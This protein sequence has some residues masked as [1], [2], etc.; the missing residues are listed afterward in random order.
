MEISRSQIEVMLTLVN[1]AQSND[2]CYDFII[3]NLSD[4]EKS[5]FGT[6]LL[7]KIIMDSTTDKFCMHVDDVQSFLGYNL[8]RDFLTFMRRHLSDDDFQIRK[9]IDANKMGRPKEVHY[10]TIDSVCKLGMSAQTP[11]G[12]ETRKYY[13][14]LERLLIEFCTNKMR[15]QDAVIQAQEETIQKL[16]GRNMINQELGERVYVFQDASNGIRIGK[17]AWLKQRN[18]PYEMHNPNGNMEYA[19][20][21][22]NGLT[23][24]RLTHHILNQFHAKDRKSWYECD[25]T[26]AHEVINTGQIFLD[27]LVGY[28]EYLEDF[29]MAE[30]MTELMNEYHEFYKSKTSSPD[31]LSNMTQSE[32]ETPIHIQNVR[33]MVKPKEIPSSSS[34]FG[35][36]TTVAMKSQDDQID[37]SE[38]LFQDLVSAENDP[39]NLAKFVDDL[40]LIDKDA[41]VTNGQVTN[42]YKFWCNNT[43][44]DK[45]D[46]MLVYMKGRFKE[47]RGEYDGVLKGRKTILLGLKLRPIIWKLPDTPSHFDRFVA[48]N[49]IVDCS[50]RTRKTR[51]E[52]AYKTWVNSRAETR[53]EQKNLNRQLTL[54]EAHLSEHFIYDIVWLGK[55]EGQ[56]LGYLGIGIPNELLGVGLHPVKDARMGARR[57]F[58]KDIGTGEIVKMFDTQSEAADYL[59][60]APSAVTIAKK[61]K[62]AICHGQYLILTV[63]DLSE[64]EKS[65]IT[66]YNDALLN[67]Q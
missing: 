66:T 61:T 55:E 45:R 64:E 13:V 33:T 44:K 23:L 9:I 10:F 31:E 53:M 3:K 62:R 34:L 14:H 65:M 21:C 59:K 5:R 16:K 27:S 56:Q 22:L 57:I 67:Q 28:A 58:V 36:A 51:V 43:T 50:A 39:D 30:R 52:G 7:R 35:S 29:K 1:S 12:D 41:S 18:T 2:S 26:L 49:F 8:K 6:V 40:F 38:I 32:T 63:D 24:E 48:E 20:H 37:N 11:E 54:L 60:V 4:S 19:V 25:K 17:T 42:V 47:Q 46:K 15:E